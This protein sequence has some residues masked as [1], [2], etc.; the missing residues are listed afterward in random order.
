MSHSYDIEALHQQWNVNGFVV[1]ENLIA[2]EILDHI[3]EAWAPL[4]DADIQ[5]QGEF[6]SRGRFRYNVRVPFRRPFVDPEIFEHSALVEFLELVLGPDYVW[7]HFDSNIPLPGTEYQNWHRDGK[8]T[9]FQGIRTPAFSVGVKFPLVDTNEENGSFELLPGTQ[10]VPDEDVPTD[11]DAVFGRGNG[12]SDYHRIRLNLKKGSLWVQDPR[13]FH[14]GTPNRSDHPRDELCMAFCRPW[15]F[16]TWLHEHTQK[17]FP[18]E[19]WESLSGH[20]RHV[21]RCQR[22]ED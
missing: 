10:F 22:V 1:F 15:L 9:L 21:L 14:R 20:A 17:D 6:P 8:A 2:H 13:A 11:L 4:R 18:Y 3:A 12:P 7:S 5:H 16:N 19:L